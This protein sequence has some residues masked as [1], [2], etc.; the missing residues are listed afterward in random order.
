MAKDT[1]RYLLRMPQAMRARLVE[2]AEKAGRSFNSE[3]LHRLALSLESGDGRG[4]ATEGSHMSRRALRWTVVTAA[5][6]FV[7]GGVLVAGLVTGGAPTAKPKAVPK[8]AIFEN[9]EYRFG[10]GGEAIG[11][12]DYFASIDAY[13]AAEVSPKWHQR[14]K[15]TFNAAV[16]R[17]RTSKAPN[18][19]LLNVWQNYGPQVHARTPGI[20]SYAGATYNTAS[21][22]AA[23]V[24]SPRCGQPDNGP[25]GVCRMW[26]GPVGGGVWVTDD[27]TAADPQWRWVSEE[28][29]QNAVGD[30]VMAPN[31][32]QE[33]T[34]YAGTGEPNFCSS[35]CSAG[36]GLWRSTDGGEA[37]TKVP[38]T[39]VSNGTYACV[40]PGQD[41]FLGR[42]ISEIVIDP[43]NAQHLL[44]GSATAARSISHIIGLGGQIRTGDPGANLPG[45]Y[46][47]FDGGN[48][49]TPVWIPDPD[50]SPFPGR[51]GV[52]DVGLD[53]NNTDVVYAAAIHRG[54]FRRCPSGAP[55]AC[56]GESGANQFDFKRVFAPRLGEPPTANNELERTMFDLTIAPN[57]GN[58]TRIY[59]TT[60]QNGVSPGSGESPSSFWRTDNANL[61]SAALLAS[62][63]AP[64][65]ET[66]PAPP[67]NPFG[68]PA[69]VYNGWQLLT[70]N[71]L[72]SPYWATHNFCTGQCWYDQDVYTPK[73]PSNPTLISAL[74]PDEVYVL[75]SYNYNE[76]P[77]YTKGTS[78]F[79]GPNA[80]I[81]NARG[82]LFST[83]A[84]DPSGALDRTFTDM[85]WDGQNVQVPWCA[86]PEFSSCLVAHNQIHPD[87]HEIVINPSRPT[88]FFEGSDGG[89]ARTNGAYIDLSR[90]CDFRGFAPAG[91]PPLSGDR[92]TQCRR[93][94]SRIP[95]TLS[96][97]N[98]KLGNTI[99]FINVAANPLNTCEVVGGTQDNG[100]W[101]SNPE[102]NSDVWTQEIYGDGGNAGFDAYPDQ[103]TQRTT[104]PGQQA[105]SAASPDTCESWMFNEYTG[106]FTDANFRSG[107]PTKW[108]VIY[109]PMFFSGEPFAFY[110][111]QIPDPNPPVAFTGERTHPIFAGGRHVW[112]SWAFGAGRPTAGAGQVQQTSPDIAFYEANCREFV[113]GP[114]PNCGDFKPLG[115]P[116]GLNQPGDLGGSVYGSDRAG[117]SVSALARRGADTQTMWAS[118]SAGRVFVTFNANDNLTENVVWHRIDNLPT[119]GGVTACAPHPGPPPG[120]AV[121]CSPTRHP[122][123]IYPDPLSPDAAYISYSGFNA[124]TPSTPGHVFRIQ[125]TRNAQGVPTNASFTNLLVEGG[126]P[127]PTP[128]NNGDLPVNDVVADDASLFTNPTSGAVRPVLYA[129]TDFGVLKGQPAAAPAPNQ[130]QTIYNWTNTA[131]MPRFEVTHLAMI[132]GQRDACRSALC[133]QGMRLMYAA[134]HSQG[135]WV[136]RLR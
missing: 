42:G 60:G 23:I 77:C 15:A 24:I 8:G 84:G 39:C 72:A 102:C 36:A 5:A 123:G 120:G 46:E 22:N 69:A 94:L 114:D 14:A 57:N 59:L 1:Y 75:G 131:G 98:T 95:N 48:T 7:I 87:Q 45:L 135:V 88:Q 18:P 134:T 6:L 37:W 56:G 79:G 55:A 66:P 63:G 29:G 47:S 119:A 108:V 133:A 118:T 44:V 16:R 12:E 41:A 43:N 81:S 67:G 64:G 122:N 62:Q 105:C 126:T 85:T 68:S 112:R 31:D 17:T 35:G 109:S 19:G 89:I 129:A 25:L 115:G 127:F 27:A 58:K 92:L 51:R 53:P 34:L 106:P 74:R 21:R 136:N 3:V 76:M 50:P 80:G 125:L 103:A 86:T 121:N 28:F 93:L 99:Q 32:P 110:Y 30:I 20:I 54:V 101:S 4:T 78:C 9:A 26:S 97:I 107:D 96:T 10:N 111:P 70:S 2:S 100:T 40:T 52:T 104:K 116:A 117:G 13:P 49:F 65:V 130:N 33:R 73:H 90:A 128:T 83:T 71:S 38:G 11:R 124:A 61:T 91:I 113:T 132:P 82:V